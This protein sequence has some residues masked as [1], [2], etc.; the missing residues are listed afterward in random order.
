MTEPNR[1]Y[2]LAV[3]FLMASR[4]LVDEL[5]THLRE[6]GYSDIRPAH[7]FAFQLLAPNGA[8]INEIG[9]HLGVTKQA[10]SQM[11]EYLEQ[12]SYVSRQPHPGDKRNKVVLLTAKG[13]E[14]IKA[15]EKILGNLEQQWSDLLGYERMAT[16]RVDLHRLI[17][18]T[19]KGSWPNKLRPAW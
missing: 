17:L 19:N 1:N 18:E 13:W 14:C 16:L 3:L 6:A 5:H 8:T 15:V 2:E 7:G 4:V 10:A 11:V 9:E 12:H